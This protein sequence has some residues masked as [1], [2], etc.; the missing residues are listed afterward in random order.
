LQV[1]AQLYISEDIAASILGVIQEDSSRSITWIT[2][3]R[4]Q[5]APGT[6][7]PIYTESYHRSLETSSASL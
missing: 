7:I 1:G 6:Y 2:W 4:Q 5:H 3:E